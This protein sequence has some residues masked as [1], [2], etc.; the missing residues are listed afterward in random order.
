M[1]RIVFKTYRLFRR[2]VL[3]VKTVGNIDGRYL[4]KNWSST[5]ITFKARTQKEAMRKADKFWKD[6]QFGMGSI[7]VMET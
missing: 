2:K 5:R 1:K 6:G 3:S 7:C 4:D